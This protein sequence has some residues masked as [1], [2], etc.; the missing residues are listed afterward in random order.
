MWEEMKCGAYKTVRME[1]EGITS[2]FPYTTRNA[3][4]TREATYVRTSINV[5]QRRVRA[6]TVAVEKQ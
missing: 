2:G 4:I 3:E 1:L 5:T 6:T